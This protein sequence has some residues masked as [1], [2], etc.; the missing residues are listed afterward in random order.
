MS[1]LARTSVG[2][3]M[4][5]EEASKLDSM[6]VMSSLKASALSKANVIEGW[7][8][9]LKARSLSSSLTNFNGGAY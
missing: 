3:K 9:G 7:D 5:T 1:E 6:L 8:M 2:L 4:S